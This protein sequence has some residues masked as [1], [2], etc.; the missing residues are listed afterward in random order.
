MVDQILSTDPV[1][2]ATL[3]GAV[4]T[5]V[6]AAV[7]YLSVR[8][9]KRQVNMLVRQTMIL[10]SQNDPIPYIKSLS[11][12][13]NK[14]NITVE[15]TGN[16]PASSLAIGTMFVPAERTFHGDSE[17]EKPLSGTE[18]KDALEK[19]KQLYVRYEMGRENLIENG[20]E[21]TPIKLACLLINKPRN[22]MVLLP[23]ETCSYTIDLSYGLRD[24][25]GSARS[26]PHYDTLVNL[27]KEN[28]VTCFAL[29]LDLLCKNMAEDPIQDQSIAAFVV[30]L[31]IHSSIE[32]AHRENIA[33][34]FMT[35]GIMELAERGIPLERD[36]YLLGKSPVNFPKSFE[37]GEL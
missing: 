25:K 19:Q 23:H 16:G 37:K 1:T 8:E 31:N 9:G 12:D 3:L 33:P 28:G 35:I 20:R 17:S 21:V 2:L 24:V 36:E 27:L 7:T 34:H 26:W 14:L 4:A 5:V 10:R 30:D 15:N 6:L 29:G 13:K 18:I 11:F 22:T 32:E